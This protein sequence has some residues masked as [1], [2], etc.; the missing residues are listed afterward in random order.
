M[1]GTSWRF[2]ERKDTRPW[3]ERSPPNRC[4][5]QREAGTTSCC[6][7]LKGGEPRSVVSSFLFYFFL[8]NMKQ[9]C[10]WRNKKQCR[11]GS[12][13]PWLPKTQV[14]QMV[15]PSPTSEVNTRT[16]DMMA[17]PG[18]F[19]PSLGESFTTWADS[20]IHRPEIRRILGTFI[21]TDLG[22]SPDW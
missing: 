2:A 6:S 5:C 19:E 13:E 11:G 4:V 1:L 12:P 17:P 20:F 10:Q 15:V 8:A 18:L 16:W 9:T 7:T 22:F 3:V 21:V 14:N